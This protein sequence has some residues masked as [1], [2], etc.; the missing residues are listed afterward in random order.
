MHL[1][2]GYVNGLPSRLWLPYP[3]IRLFGLFIPHTAFVHFTY[4]FW[5]NFYSVH[6]QVLVITVVWALSMQIQVMCI[7]IENAYVRGCL[8]HQTLATLENATGL[9]LRSIRGGRKPLTTM[10]ILSLFSSEW[11]QLN[12]KKSLL[13]SYAN[14]FNFLVFR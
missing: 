10:L 1:R 6:E 12:R 8:V 14:F 7:W 5:S 3:I 11:G 2:K 9:I 4:V 13:E